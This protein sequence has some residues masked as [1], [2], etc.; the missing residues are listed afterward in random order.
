MYIAL[1]HVKSNGISLF[2]IANLYSKNFKMSDGKYTLLEKVG[3]NEVLIQ[4]ASLS[5]PG[6]NGLNALLFI[7]ANSQEIANEKFDEITSH[8]DKI[9]KENQEIGKRRKRVKEP[10]YALTYQ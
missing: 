1:G 8:F 7:H 10:E 6:S 3:D 2:D 5:N 4:L 9:A